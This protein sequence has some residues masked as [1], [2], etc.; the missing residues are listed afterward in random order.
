MKNLAFAMKVVIMTIGLYMM[1]R[2]PVIS[3]PPFISG[4]A[5]FIIGLYLALQGYFGSSFS[6]CIFNNPTPKIVKKK[7]L[8]AFK[9]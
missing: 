7:G 5:I 1:I 4:L 2:F 6:G 8:F 9:K 3:N